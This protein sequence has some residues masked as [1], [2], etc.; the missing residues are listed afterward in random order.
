MKFTTD[1]ATVTQMLT[2]AGLRPSAQRVAIMRFMVE[3]RIHPTVDDIF[4]ALTSEWPTMSRTTV[5]NTLKVLSENKLIDIIDIENG[6]ARYD[7]CPNGPHAHFQCLECHNI[8]DIMEVSLPQVPE[9][10]SAFRITSGSVH[11]RGYCP[12]CADCQN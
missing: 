9:S 4:R 3:N 1:N 6:N 10:E 8:F 11:Y 12:Q 2:E 7:Y 5:Y